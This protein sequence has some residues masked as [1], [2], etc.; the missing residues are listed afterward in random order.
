[1]LGDRAPVFLETSGPAHEAGSRRSFGRILSIAVVW[2][3]HSLL[4]LP[5]LLA[6]TA[7]AAAAGLFGRSSRPGTGHGM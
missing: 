5:L 3:L 6:G 7:V 1:M 4:Y 2:T